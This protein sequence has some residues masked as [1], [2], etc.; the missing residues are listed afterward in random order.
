ML[1]ARA[2]ALDALIL[3]NRRARGEG[4]LALETN[5]GASG[6]GGAGGALPSQPQAAD[7][8]FAVFDF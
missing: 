1:Q 8:A 5:D 3:T 7:D 6:V 2:T 4:A